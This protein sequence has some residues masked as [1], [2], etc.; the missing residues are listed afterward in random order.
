MTE[1]AEM[2]EKMMRLYSSLSIADNLHSKW[3]RVLPWRRGMYTWRHDV[4]KKRWDWLWENP[5][6]FAEGGI[7]EEV[8]TR[9]E[10]AFRMGVVFGIEYERAYPT[11]EQE[12]WPVD[13]EER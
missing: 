6:E 4:I 5:E 11:G 3:D 2:P 7:P 10:Y 12:K 13:L 9:E 8:D 1:T